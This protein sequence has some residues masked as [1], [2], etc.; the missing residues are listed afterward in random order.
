[1][2]KSEKCLPA[3]G[4]SRFFSSC[5]F[6]HCHSA[7]PSAVKRWKKQLT[8]EHP[9]GNTSSAM[10]ARRLFRK[11]LLSF[12]LLQLGQPAAKGHI[13]S[14][15]D[16]LRKTSA[17]GMQPT[18]HFAKFQPVFHVP[19]LSYPFPDECSFRI[20]L[21]GQQLTFVRTKQ[22]SAEQRPVFRYCT[23]QPRRGRKLPGQGCAV[24]RKFISRP[25]ERGGPMMVFRLPRVWGVILYCG[26][27]SFS[28][29]SA[30]PHLSII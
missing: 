15:V 28:S 19:L 22:S 1:M 25:L 6:L 8:E 14:P 17:A 11:H 21:K 9:Q 26:L 3:L 2:E 13:Q 16:V 30:C 27:I 7:V 4:C 20:I 10:L 18:C 23:V 29:R 12:I 24:C 5:V